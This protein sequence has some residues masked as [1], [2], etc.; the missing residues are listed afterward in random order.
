LARILLSHSRGDED[1]LKFFLSIGKLASVEIKPVEFE[2]I[3][4]PAW[5]YIRDLMS[6]S[7][8]FFLL[9]GKNIIDRGIY[10]QNWISFEVGLA[11]EMATTL[12]REVWV[13]EPRQ[14]KVKFPV[15]F[16]NH[17]L[18]F[19]MNEKSHRNFIRAVIEAYK[20]DTF[21]RKIPRGVNVTCPH[22]EVSFSLHSDAKD[23]DCPAC[24]RGILLV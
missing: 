11:C 21:L 22:C 4:A 24:R 5:S 19:D 8:A 6:T 18:L 7:D 3:Q 12:R 9:L 15:P 1:I 13:F 2:S 20:Q 16:L 17:Y 23:F 10:T 14:H